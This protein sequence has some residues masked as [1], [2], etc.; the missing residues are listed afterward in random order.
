MTPTTTSN[1]ASWKSSAASTTRPYWTSD[2]KAHFEEVSSVAKWL[3]ASLLHPTAARLRI[4]I[5]PNSP[6]SRV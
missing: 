2:T 3:T 5:N 4:G 6:L 1:A